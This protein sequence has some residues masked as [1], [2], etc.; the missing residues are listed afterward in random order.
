[1]NTINFGKIVKD[2]CSPKALAKT[3][4]TG[5]VTSVASTVAAGII[6]GVISGIKKD[7][8]VEKETK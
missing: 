5:A 1:M 8:P 6:L 4:V 3:A 7:K 2:V